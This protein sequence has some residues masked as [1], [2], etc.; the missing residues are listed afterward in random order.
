MVSKTF[1]FLKDVLFFCDNVM[2]AQPAEDHRADK[3]MLYEF[4]AFLM[5]DE[6]HK[7]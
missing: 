2:G 4:H 7:H 3:E 5:T 6:T 1:F